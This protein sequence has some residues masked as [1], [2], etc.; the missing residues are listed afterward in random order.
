LKKDAL[1]VSVHQCFGLVV[2]YADD[3]LLLSPSLTVLQQ[4]LYVCENVIGSVDLSVNPQK[5]VCTRI[6][7]R[8]NTIS[9]KLLA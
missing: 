8:Y 6:G 7:R 5:Y 3:I 4:L 9:F 2:M 1:A